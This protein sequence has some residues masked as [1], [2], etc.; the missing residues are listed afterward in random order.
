MGVTKYELVI[1]F[2]KK[3]KSHTK[4]FME[5]MSPGSDIYMLRKLDDNSDLAYMVFDKGDDIPNSD[6]KDFMEVLSTGGDI[7]MKEQFDIDWQN[8]DDELHLDVSDR[9]TFHHAERHREGQRRDQ[10]RLRRRMRTTSTTST[11][12]ENL[13]TPRVFRKRIHEFETAHAC[14]YISFLFETVCRLQLLRD[15]SVKHT[16]CFFFA[17]PKTVYQILFSWWS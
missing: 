17:G 11:T 1:N 14:L 7:T 12:N 16:T 2:G 3:A 4:A 8:N 9:L 5:D 10:A 6:I 15:S 13:R